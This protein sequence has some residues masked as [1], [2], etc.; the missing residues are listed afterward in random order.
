M[1][2]LLTRMQDYLVH[3]QLPGGDSNAAVPAA[4]VSYLTSV[5]LPSAADMTLRNNRELRT[6]AEILDLL[7]LGR[8]LEAGDVVA[9]RFRAVEL[10]SAEGT[11][12][13]ARHLELIPEARVSVT[14]TEA[15]AE[16]ARLERLETKVRLGGPSSSPGGSGSR[17]GKGAG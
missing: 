4:A 15:R 17:G 12:Q 11:W 14:S 16:A 2:Q 5:L 7:A 1:A 9:Q 10:A 8:V 3:R 13:L 6:L